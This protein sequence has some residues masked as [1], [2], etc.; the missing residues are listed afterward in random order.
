VLILFK[1]EDPPSIDYAEIEEETPEKMKVS[2]VRGVV[3][4]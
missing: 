2:G 4:L 1:D 3:S